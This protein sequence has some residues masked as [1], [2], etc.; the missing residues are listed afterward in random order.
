MVPVGA[1]TL[2]GWSS[3]QCA[4]TH[5]GWQSGT[6]PTAG[7]GGAAC[8]AVTQRHA[9]QHPPSWQPGWRGYIFRRCMNGYP[10]HKV[11]GE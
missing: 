5:P 11:V 6:G 3:L 8:E 10:L 2:P 9:L 4:T 1:G 7:T